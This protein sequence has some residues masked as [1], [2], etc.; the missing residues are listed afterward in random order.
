MAARGTNTTLV[1]LILVIVAVVV[2]V[3][4]LYVQLRTDE[5]SS[6]V[7]EGEILR[8]LFVAE[9]EGEPFLSFVLF[10]HPETERIAVLDI[11]GNVG[12]VLRPL[13]RVDSISRVFDATDIAP[14]RREVESLTGRSISATVVL[15]RAQLVGLVD[16]LGGLELFIVTDYQSMEEEVLIMLPAGNVVL[17]GE[18][19][20]DYLLVQDEAESELERTG[21]RQA[22]VQALLRELRAGSDLLQ[23]PEVLDVRDRLLNTRLDRRAR[24]S[25][26]AALEGMDVE[27]L[28][29]RRVQGT[30]R[31]VSVEGQSVPLLFPHFEGQWLKQSVDQIELTLA[32]ND[33]ESEGRLVVSVEILNGTSSAGIARRT[34]QLYEGFGFEVRR[35]GNAESDQVEHTIV[36]DRRGEGTQAG[37]VAQVIGAQRIVSEVTP[38]S[39]VDVTLILGRDFDGTVVRTD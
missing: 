36:I 6:A 33:V 14:Y 26:F 9:E 19:A 18:K 3:G 15:S 16:L 25:L 35:F 5:I 4:L 11:P 27:R 32:G 37:R 7:G 39:D 8:V 31:T 23:H 21:R 24:T 20:V 30:V 38:N 1:F 17:D 34:S 13:G 10:F 28:I 22:F 2:T 29:R 12:A